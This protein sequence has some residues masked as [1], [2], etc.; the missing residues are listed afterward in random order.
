MQ[1]SC[2]R[3]AVRSFSTMLFLALAL[4][5]PPALADY[6]GRLPIGNGQPVSR[7]GDSPPP[8]SSLFTPPGGLKAVVYWD[9]V[10]GTPRYVSMRSAVNPLNYSGLDK[11][12]LIRACGEFIEQNSSFFGVASSD[13]INP[14]VLQVDK[15]WLVAFEEASAGVPIRGANIRIL[16]DSFGTIESVKSFLYR[17][18]P[19]QEYSFVPF[20]PIARQLADWKVEIEFSEKQLYFPLYDPASMSPVW[21]VRGLDADGQPW[22][23]F[24]DPA[25]GELREQ[26]RIVSELG[27]ISGVVLGVSP[28]PD[29]L[30][31]SAGDAMVSGNGFVSYPI[32]GARV[33]ELKGARTDSVAVNPD[34]QFTIGLPGDP[35][36]STKVEARIEYGL[37]VGDLPDAIV[38]WKNNYNPLLQI[39]TGNDNCNSFSS[40]NYPM[41]ELNDTQIGARDCNFL[42]NADNDLIASA[43]LLA[44]HHVRSF[45]DDTFPRMKQY[46]IPFHAYFPIAFVVPNNDVKK[47]EYYPNPSFPKICFS[48]TIDPQDHISPDHVQ[49][50]TPTLVNHEYAHHLIY[51]MTGTLDS[52]SFDCKNPDSGAHCIEGDPDWLQIREGQIVEGIADALAAYKAGIPTF[53]YYEPNFPGWMGYDIS[54]NIIDTKMPRDRFEVAKA[55]WLLRDNFRKN[56]YVELAT[57]LIY[58]WLGR[59]NPGDKFGNRI[60]DGSQVLM[61]EILD[62]LDADHFTPESDADRTTISFFDKWVMDAFAGRKFFYGEFVR[63]DADQNEELDISDPVF[64]LR[65]E[66]DGGIE[67]KCLDAM[68][69]D[70]DNT[71]SI[72]D[73]IYVL[74]F[75]FMGGEAPPA[76]FPKCSI[77]PNIRDDDFNCYDPTCERG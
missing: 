55:L 60:F 27:E 15:S 44:F 29:N 20:E 5:P 1:A 4:S 18:P 68:D 72:T 17:D 39:G 49:S 66:F 76:P 13:L 22:E 77:D 58:R 30:Y 24:F 16:L 34:G 33:G 3:L 40:F 50:M 7:F 51:I 37:D 48:P 69:A 43:G 38:P 42:F 46:N 74:S 52:K 10:L 35:G 73:P 65:Y 14:S 26:R 2:V 36:T 64:M 70:G 61:E 53:G 12:N 67:P 32:P 21:Y 59:N 45:M 63:G 75:L 31:A 62:A 56:G 23:Y 28:N 8:Y 9:L 41:I 25:T 57:D 19:G 47:R 54:V 6:G 71:I 11:E